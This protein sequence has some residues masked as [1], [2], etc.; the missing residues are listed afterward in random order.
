MCVGNCAASG[1]RAYTKLMK[2]MLAA[3]SGSLKIAC[4]VR[5]FMKIMPF[6]RF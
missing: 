4:T 3:C 2:I 1:W 5:F 6:S